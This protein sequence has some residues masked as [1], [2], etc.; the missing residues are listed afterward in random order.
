MQAVS[1]QLIFTINPTQGYSNLPPTK[2]PKICNQLDH[3]HTTAS[4]TNDAQDIPR[5]VPAPVRTFLL[6]CVQVDENVGKDTK[7]VERHEAKHAVMLSLRREEVLRLMLC[8]HVS[9]TKSGGEQRLG[10]GRL[11]RR[12]RGR[13][14]VWLEER[15]RGEVARTHDD[16]KCGGILETEIGSKPNDCLAGRLLVAHLDK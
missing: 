12:T 9:D 10:F 13:L 5:S 16:C 6:T 15:L 11:R 14:R 1:Q 8:S 4:Q 7:Q 3:E 2:S